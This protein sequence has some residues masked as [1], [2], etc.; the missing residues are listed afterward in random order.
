MK[1]FI[2]KGVLALVIAGSISMS[3]GQVKI[4]ANPGT[5]GAGALL[6]LENEA[7][8]GNNQKGLVLPSVSLTTTATWAPLAGSAR[9]GTVVLNTNADVTGN[10]ANGA[11]VYYWNASQWRPVTD[12]SL[13]GNNIQS[14]Q[15]LGTNNTQ[16]LNIRANGVNRLSI[17]GNT[18]DANYGQAR[19]IGGNVSV[20]RVYIQRP[21]AG[22]PM[23]GLYVE[24]SA[25]FNSAAPS[26]IVVGNIANHSVQGV[27]GFVR[28]GY[29]DV[30][31][32]TNL[33]A[34]LTYRT[35]NTLGFS[36]SAE[37]FSPGGGSDLLQLT[38]NRVVNILDGTLNV[39][40]TIRVAVVNSQQGGASEA[41]ATEISS[42]ASSYIGL[43]P[44]LGA[45]AYYKIPSAG[46]GN[47][48]LILYIRNDAAVEAY[49]STAGGNFYSGGTASATLTLP[50]RQSAT[51]I[52]NGSNWQVTSIN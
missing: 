2:P 48:G 18:E 14:N 24:S 6:E 3:Y 40:G 33:S 42:T 35:N 9:N 11:G 32:T 47:A 34:A 12:W 46:S 29:A 1:N 28:N 30:A 38:S 27:Y 22:G 8:D 41:E 44:D 16:D 15:V 51:I 37:P 17:V 26:N 7:A 39:G 21:T 49:L 50:A 52:S 45:G 36:I 13:V 4:G 19:F 5:I 43:R 25:G 10:L 31:P 20:P 23:P